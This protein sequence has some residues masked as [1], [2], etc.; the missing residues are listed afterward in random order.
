ME[1]DVNMKLKNDP[2][3][4]TVNPFKRPAGLILLMLFQM[5]VSFKGGLI[6]QKIKDYRSSLGWSQN[7]TRIF[8]ELSIIISDNDINIDD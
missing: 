2:L 7:H 3:I 4:D 6:N 8:S 1:S 5:R